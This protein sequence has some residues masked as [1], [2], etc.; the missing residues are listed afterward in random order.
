MRTL[1]LSSD[2]DE[3]GLLAIDSITVLVVESSCIVLAGIAASISSKS[4]SDDL[5]SLLNCMKAVFT[6]EISVC[7]TIWC[8]W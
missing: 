8:N 7:F 3:S 4:T 5:N 1:S 6:K 2:A